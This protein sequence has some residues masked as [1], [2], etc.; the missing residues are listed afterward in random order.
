MSTV[1]TSLAR[2]AH[3]DD[4]HRTS[5]AADPGPGV[6]G[7]AR[8]YHHG[9]LAQALVAEGINLAS[10]S[11]PDAVVLREVARRVGVSPTAAYR[12]FDNQQALQHAVKDAALGRL[13]D[14][15]QAAV[16]ALP[17][18]SVGNADDPAELAVRRLVAIGEAYFAFAMEQ[19]GLFRCFCMGLPLAGGMSWGDEDEPAFGVLTAVLDDLVSVGSLDPD[20]RP[21]ADLAAWSAV[22]GLAMLC[23]DGPLAAL[24]VAEKEALVGA[25]VQMVLRGILR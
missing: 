2:T 13:A 3:N 15:M 11:G 8:R 7:R 17:A 25:T 23:L 14:H 16:A 18:G 4:V 5:A 9:N 19:E 24:P 1:S 21:G 20:R 12:H 22:H 6:R 10:E